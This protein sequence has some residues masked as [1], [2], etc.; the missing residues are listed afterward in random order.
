MTVI[1]WVNDERCV[2][3]ETMLAAVAVL[4]V[5][6]VLLLPALKLTVEGHGMLLDPPQ[7]V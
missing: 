2:K 4:P 7:S 3:A 5:V 6:M 1:I